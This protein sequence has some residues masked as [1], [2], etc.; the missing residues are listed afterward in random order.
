MLVRILISMLSKSWTI[1]IGADVRFF[2][3]PISFFFIS[4]T[5]FSSASADAWII[6]WPLHFSVW[7]LNFSL[8]PPQSTCM[9]TREFQSNP[10]LVQQH[11]FKSMLKSLHKR[12]RFCNTSS[13]ISGQ[14]ISNNN[15]FGMETLSWAFLFSTNPYSH[16]SV[17]LEWAP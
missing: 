11:L 5:E 3:E 1:C 13:D 2:K 6:H 9:D 14:Q 16:K 12:I 10:S 17:L 7:M 15:V 4:N 8:L